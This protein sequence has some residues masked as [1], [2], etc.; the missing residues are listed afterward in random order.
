MRFNK[1]EVIYKYK[2]I[3]NIGSGSFGEVWLALDQSISSECALKLLIN[4][5][6]IDNRLFEARIGNRLKHTNLVN[7]KYADIIRHPTIMENIVAIA[8]PYYKN[9]SVTSII[10][11]CNFLDTNIAVNCLI[12]MLKG[13]EYLHENGFYHCDI[14]PSNVLIGNNNEYILSDYGISCFSPSKMAVK[15]KS[16]YLP[17]IS[18]ETLSTNKYDART[19]I[20]QLGLTAFRFLC[21]IQEIKSD[22]YVLNNGNFEKAVLEGQL[23]TEKKFKPFVPRKLRKIVCKAVSVDPNDRYQTALEMRRELERVSIKGYATSDA[24]GR[25]QFISTGKTYRY[26]IISTLK[27]ES[28]FIVFQKN[29]KTGRETIAHKYCEKSIKNSNINKKIQSLANEFI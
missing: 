8:M 7:I 15:P 10:N 20:Y 3:S 13:L 5:D 21:G 29:N 2:L 27:N 9:G 17:H 16:S 24:N 26:E 14:K 12:D 22:F 11:S 18:P 19:D 4:N 1:D 28:N 6:S 23:I 25:I